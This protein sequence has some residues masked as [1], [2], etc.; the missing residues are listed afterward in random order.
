MKKVSFGFLV[1]VFHFL[2]ICQFFSFLLIYK[3]YFL[4]YIGPGSPPRYVSLTSISSYSVLVTWA[5][6]FKPNGYITQYSVHIDY[7]NGSGDSIPVF[8]NEFEIMGLSPYQLIEVQVS[9]WTAIGEGPRS[10][11]KMVRTEEASKYL[12]TC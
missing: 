7:L 11:L 12:F 6:P 1:S 9:A 2:P 3:F 10:D 8:K 5:S 4:F